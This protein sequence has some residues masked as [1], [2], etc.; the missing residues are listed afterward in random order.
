MNVEKCREEVKK[1][2]EVL[3]NG[4]VI[5]YPTDTIWGIGCD[6]TNDEAVKR[7]YELKKR[8]D[9]KA[10]LVLL[11]DLGKLASYVDVPDITYD[12]LEAADRPMTV[13]YPHAKNLAKGLVSADGTIGIRITKEIFSRMLVAR[14]R[15]PIVSTSANISGDPSPKCFADISD[16]VKKSVDYVVDFRQEET[17]NPAPS[18][19]VK[20]GLG[21]EIQIIRQ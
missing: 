4:G 20:L 7:V 3:K 5:L 13:I 15:K 19:I 8:E 11:D 21:G 6:A 14:F 12:L 10:L 9:S 1:A 16:E 2:C 18:S 17:T